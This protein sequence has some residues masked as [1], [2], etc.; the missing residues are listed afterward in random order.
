MTSLRNL[1][2]DIPR[3]LAAERI[4]VLLDTA[5][6]RLERIVSVGHATPAGEWYDQAR[7]E[8]VVVLRGR[9]RVRIEGE[10]EDRALGVGDHLLLRAHVRHRVEWTDPTE[11]TVWLAVFFG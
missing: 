5:A 6:V 10:A 7:D 3:V 11:P 2:D 4:D 8:W 1:F 9:A